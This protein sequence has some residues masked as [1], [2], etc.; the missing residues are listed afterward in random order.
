MPTYYEYRGFAG[1]LAACGV[2]V[3]TAQ[4][5]CDNIGA[6]HAPF[7]IVKHDVEDKPAKALRVSRIEHQLGIAATYYVHSFFLDDPKAVAVFRQMADLGHE[8]GYHYDVL[9]SNNGNREAAVTEFRGV[10]RKFADCGFKIRTVCPHGNPIKERVGYSSNKDFFLD[11]SIRDLFPEIVDIY[12]VFPE[13]VE[14]DYVYVSDA[15]Y[16]YSYRY[17][18]STST[19]ATEQSIPLDCKEKVVKLVRD[20]NSMILST[21]THR[22]F[23]YAFISWIRI[24]LFKIARPTAR[25][26]FRSAFGKY[27]L[28]K[29]YFM[30]KKI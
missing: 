6:L 24:G 11:R 26:L 14:K 27:L 15:G 17:A 20:G 5:A 13:M 12:V 22:Y 29:L 23:R 16:A 4:K 2:P 18:K 19:D 7:L 8:I 28:D 3:Y 9:D 1:Q 21:H 30:A 10:I 25:V